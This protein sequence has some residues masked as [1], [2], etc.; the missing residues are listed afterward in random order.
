M[1]QPGQY[2]SPG[3]D[4][5]ACYT[6]EWLGSVVCAVAKELDA[7]P[8]QLLGHSFGGLVAREAVLRE[9]ASFR[10]LTL[11]GS[12]PAAIGGPRKDRM[13]AIEPLLPLGMSAVYQAVEQL[14][15]ADPRWVNA[16]PEL[17][18]FLKERFIA[19]SAAGLKG[20]GDA[21]LAE[22]DRVDE[23]AT[24]GIPTLVCCGEHDDAWRPE[25]QA[26]MARRLG[27]RHEVIAGSVHSPAIENPVATLDVLAVFWGES[28]T[29]T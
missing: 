19:S 14:A 6:V 12:G 18:A 10:S 20:M 3:P 21:L 25:T 4:D 26:T 7:G 22:P 2:Q 1:D 15:Q 28:D 8:L 17:R 24:S 9:S 23:L 5:P 27:A 11:L 29:A 13:A 16:A